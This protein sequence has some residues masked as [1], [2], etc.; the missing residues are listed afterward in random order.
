MD[1]T[2]QSTPTGDT[3]FEETNN[4]TQSEQD[5]KNDSVIL[6]QPALEK[7]ITPLILSNEA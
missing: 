6:T 4:S 3:I 2:L 5:P 7:P 1:D